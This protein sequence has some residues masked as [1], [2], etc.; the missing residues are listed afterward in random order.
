MD[1]FSAA[2]VVAQGLHAERTLM[3]TTSSN[4]ANANTTRTAE[5]G[6]YKRLD[7]VFQAT[8][9]EQTAFSK[10]L[11]DV[12]GVQVSEIKAD[13]SEGRLVYDPSHPDAS[14]EGYVRMPNV[15]VVEEMVN[16]IEAS[17]GYEAGVKAM[18]TL[19]QMAERAIAIGK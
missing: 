13:K 7:P 14:A 8:P 5:G 1:F 11:A 19:S 2:D 15:N 3:N 12:S 18:G 6:P 9:V 16:M 17:R 4:L 10:E